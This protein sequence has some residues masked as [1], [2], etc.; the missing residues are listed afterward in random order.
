MDTQ[1]NID[2]FVFHAACAK[3][4]DCRCQITLSNY[5]KIKNADKTI[6]LL[7]QNDF[8]KRFHERGSWNGILAGGSFERKEIP[9][10]V[11]VSSLENKPING[12]AKERSRSVNSISLIN[13][14]G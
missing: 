14:S 2:G 11:I 6:L 3:C 4:V 7:C 12:S 13:D 8:Y 5:T 9:E 1:I 10:T